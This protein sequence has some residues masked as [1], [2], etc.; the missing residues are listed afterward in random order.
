MELVQKDRV[1]N[2]LINDASE[3]ARKAKMNPF[4]KS[5]KKA[6]AHILLTIE[7]EAATVVTF[8]LT[9]EAATETFSNG[10][11]GWDWDGKDIGQNASSTT[12]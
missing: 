9:S 5:D 1:L 10:I 2:T 4:N 11:K 3:D 8:V 7:E 12:N 6:L